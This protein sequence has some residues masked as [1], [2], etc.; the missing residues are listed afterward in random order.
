MVRTL[1]RGIGAIGLV[2]FLVGILAISCSSMKGVFKRVDLTKV[3]LGMSKREVIAALEKDPANIVAAKQYE[4]GTMEVLEYHDYMTNSV[5]DN[6]ETYWLYF[7]NDSLVEWGKPPL[8]WE[9]YVERL[10]KEQ[11]GPKMP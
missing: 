11:R 7:F 3:D 1:T 10:Y 2:Y 9:V 6:Y 5:R 8:D 4:D